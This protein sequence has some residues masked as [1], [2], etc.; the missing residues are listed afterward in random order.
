MLTSMNFS[1]SRNHSIRDLFR[2]LQLILSSP[3]LEGF[4]AQTTILGK[5]GSGLTIDDCITALGLRQYLMFFPDHS[6]LFNPYSAG[7][8]NGSSDCLVGIRLLQFLGSRNGLLVQV[9]QLKSFFENWG[10]SKEAVRGQLGAMVRKDILWTDTGSPED[11]EDG[12]NVRLSYRGSLYNGRIVRRAIFN[13]IL[14]GTHLVYSLDFLEEEAR[15]AANWLREQ[16]PAAQA[17]LGELENYNPRG[18][19]V[20]E[21]WDRIVSRAGIRHAFYNHPVWYKHGTCVSAR[22]RRREAMVV[23]RGWWKL[24]EAA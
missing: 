13:Y 24:D 9:A 5:K 4:D 8:D 21:R 18:M 7:Q 6:P 10:Y 19:C 3:S 11:F 2:T 12:S 20:S 14:V 15:L 16:S 1:F 17:Q 22:G 23:S